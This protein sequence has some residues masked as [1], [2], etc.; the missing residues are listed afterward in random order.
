MGERKSKGE[1]GSGMKTKA[2]L[3][4]FETHLVRRD[5][6]KVARVHGAERA[7]DVA[8]ELCLYQHRAPAQIQNCEA[9]TFTASATAASA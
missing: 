4:L 7:Q 6:Q 1:G 3:E 9:R 2:H 8:V 5:P